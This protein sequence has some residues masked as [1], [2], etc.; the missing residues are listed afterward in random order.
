M[1]ARRTEG[2]GRQSFHGE[3]WIKANT[4]NVALLWDKAN[5]VLSQ[6]RHLGPR[7]YFSAGCLFMTNK[8]NYSGSS[9]ARKNAASF[10]GWIKRDASSSRQRPDT[11][12]QV[13]KPPLS[14]SRNPELPCHG[15]VRRRI[16]SPICI[17]KQTPLAGISPLAAV[18]KARRGYLKALWAAWWRNAP[19]LQPLSL[20][21][22]V[23]FPRRAC[24]AGGWRWCCFPR[25]PAGP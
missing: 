12:S 15:P 2:G 21:P 20:A 16:N 1:E 23:C 22:R 14:L 6:L 3:V 5:Q 10:T 18:S 25:R 7:R 8:V 17:P 11:F 4:I 19:P 9:V 24:V 13:A